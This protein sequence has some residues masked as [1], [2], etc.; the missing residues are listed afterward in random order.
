MHFSRIQLTPDSLAAIHHRRKRGGGLFW[1]HQMI[2]DL[3]DNTPEQKRDFLY[4][5]E[6]A[7]NGLPFYYLLSAREPGNNPIAADIQ[8]RYYR[9]ILKAGDRLQFSLRANAVVT[10]KADDRS[11]RRIRR[12]II[13]AWVD[14]YKQR[15]PDPAN[16]PPPAVIHQEAGEGWMKRQCEGHGFLLEQLRVENHQFNR[17]RKP[18]DSNIRRFTSLDLH[19]Q[20]VVSEP[21]KLLKILE[22]GLGRSKAYGCG[23]MLVRRS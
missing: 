7:A 15:F 13:E 9:P 11:K 6:D 17:V 8:T 1:E 5:R 19:G 18:G 16:R 10:R 2:W 20:L 14:H 23:L 21:E 12:D 22:R 3:F 4:R